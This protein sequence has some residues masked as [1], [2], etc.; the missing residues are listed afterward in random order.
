MARPDA[1]ASG[2]QWLV[3]I[4]NALRSTEATYPFL[5]YGYDWMAFAHLVIAISVVGP[6]RDPVRNKWVLQWLLICC[7]LVI[8]LALICGAI[9]AIPFWWR[10]IDCSFGVVGA[11]PLLYC[12]RV[13]SGLEASEIPEYRIAGTAPRRSS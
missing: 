3:L 13:V 9:R 2:L 5:F 6:I 4:R 11:V 7:V 8:P 1:Y 12:L 10:L